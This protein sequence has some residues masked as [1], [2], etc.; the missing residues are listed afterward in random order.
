MGVLFMGE[1]AV[2]DHPRT[3]AL[4]LIRQRISSSNIL[5]NLTLGGL[6]GFTETF[7]AIS[8]VSLIFSGEL[9][10]FLSLGISIALLTS[11]VTLVM[12]TILSSLPSGIGSPTF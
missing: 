6:L 2:A 7:F 1:K 8:L 10:Q 3:S 5:L 11:I 4:N 9:T 12:T